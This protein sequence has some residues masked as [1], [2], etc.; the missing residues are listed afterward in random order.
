MRQVPKERGPRTHWAAIGGAAGGIIK[1]ASPGVSFARGS[2]GSYSIVWPAYERIPS[3]VITCVNLQEFIA[4]TGLAVGSCNVVFSTT[5]GGAGVDTDFNVT[6]S[7]EWP[8]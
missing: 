2:A 4:V 6:I 1:A 5:S 3:V 8:S 7:G